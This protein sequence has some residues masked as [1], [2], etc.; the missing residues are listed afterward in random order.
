MLY[1]RSNIGHR[2]LHRPSRFR[3]STA[4]SLSAVNGGVWVPRLQTASK[5]SGRP[6]ETSTTTQQRS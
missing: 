2:C 5:R 3:N 6:I 1:T 4:V